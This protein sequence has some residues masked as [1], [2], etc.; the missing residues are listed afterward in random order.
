MDGFGAHQ[1]INL[2][3]YM[4]AFPPTLRDFL[5]SC[6]GLEFSEIPTHTTGIQRLYIQCNNLSEKLGQVISTCFP[7]INDLYLGGKV[8]ENIK[9]D[10][11]TSHL[12]FLTLKSQ[13]NGEPN[14]FLLNSTSDSQVKYFLGLP[15]GE[16]I[17]RPSVKPVTEQELWN[18]IIMHVICASAHFHHFTSL[19]LQ[20]SNNYD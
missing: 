6:T 2:T 17:G 11:P 14:R 13:F 18:R 10:V 9:I 12:I 3:E 7:K 15:L 19:D 1:P 20:N 8:A 5:V 16:R 4:N